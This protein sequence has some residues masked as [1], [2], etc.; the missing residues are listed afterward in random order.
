MQP[1]FTGKPCVP[2]THSHI[3]LCV[4]DSTWEAQAAYELDHNSKVKAWVKNDHIGFEVSYIFPQ[5]PAGL[6]VRLVSDGTLIVE[7]KRR[8]TPTGVSI[9]C[10]RV[11]HAIPQPDN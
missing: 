10:G 1:W 4:A 7:T 3:N 5:V 11:A 9:P 6:L 8:E 2:A